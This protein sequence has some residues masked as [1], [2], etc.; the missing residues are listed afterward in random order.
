[1]LLAETWSGG[2]VMYAG[3]PP[4]DEKIDLPDEFF[5][6]CHYHSQTELRKATVEP[7]MKLI[8]IIY[9]S[10]PVPGSIKFTC[11]D[12]Q[13]GTVLDCTVD[14]RNKSIVLRPL[15]PNF[16]SFMITIGKPDCAVQ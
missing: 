8:P 3:P 7:D 2:V 15:A 10:G 1:M 4:V 14:L 5:K 13:T 11:V 9:S 16:T 12:C 6:V